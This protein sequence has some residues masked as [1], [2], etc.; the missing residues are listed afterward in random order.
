MRKIILILMI[1][2]V[3]CLTSY[4]QD[5]K[6]KLTTGQTLVGTLAGATDSTVTIMMGDGEN[7]KPLV[8]PASKIFTGKLPHNGSIIIH[9]GRV[10][11]ITRE[12]IRE[13][14][15][16]KECELYS[17][18]HY[19]IGQALK[20]SGITALSIGVPCL[21]AGLA[22]CIVGYTAKTSVESMGCATAAPYL[23]GAGAA[24][25][26]VGIPLY[27]EG[28]KVLEFNITYSGNGTG[29]VMNF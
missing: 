12:S 5:L 2:I 7:I 14:K 4:A 19:A 18:P 6:L 26:I 9:D 24:L 13:Q 23:L 20:K 1:G 27:V 8:V 28:K 25:T 17:N 16:S 22:T 21:A 15:K 11:L 29:I 10:V 3:S